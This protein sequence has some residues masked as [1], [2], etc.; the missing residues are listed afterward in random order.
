MGGGDG[1]VLAPALRARLLA[2]PRL[3]GP[4]ALWLL[5]FS[6]GVDLLP[7][8]LRPRVNTRLLPR[9]DALLGYS[10]AWFAPAAPAPLDLLAAVPYTVHPVLPVFYLALAYK[11]TRQPRYWTYLFTFGVMNCLAVSTHLLWPTAPPWYFD[12]FGTAEASYALKGDPA[13]LARVDARLGIQFFTRMYRDG[14]KVVFGT[15]PS[16]HGAWPYLMAIFR[17]RPAA[18]AVRLAIWAYVVWV[19][20]AAMYLQHHFLADLIGGALYA[21]VAVAVCSAKGGDLEVD[22]VV[23]GR[24]PNL[25]PVSTEE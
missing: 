25:L 3:L 17:P 18:R 6:C 2:L 9:L 14:G 24:Q 22:Q 5:L 4:L 8:A 20:W 1:G 12:K 13:I 23:E 11:A 7:P 19:W 21:E 10:Y 15:W 16:L